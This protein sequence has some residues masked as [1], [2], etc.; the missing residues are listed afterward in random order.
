LH[1]RQTQPKAGLASAVAPIESD[2]L[3]E[4][5]LALV[6]RNSGPSVSD[7][8]NDRFGLTPAAN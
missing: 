6:G 5:T 3:A 1:D 4:D 7:F 8:Q 2:E